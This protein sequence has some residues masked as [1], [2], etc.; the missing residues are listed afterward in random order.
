MQIYSDKVFKNPIKKIFAT[1]RE[2]IIYALKEIWSL[3]SKY[4]VLGYITYE[5]D[6]LY[7]EVFDSYETFE[8]VCVSSPCGIIK[9]PLIKKKQYIKNVEKIKKYIAD[10]FTY[11]VNYTYPWD[12]K[13]NLSDFDLY[14][15][16]LNYQ[17]TPYNAYLEGKNY[18]ILSFSPELFFKIEGNKIITKPMKGTIS[19][20]KNQV[21]DNFNREFLKN[22]EKNR[23]EN[24]MIVD[25]LRNDLS[26]IA[27]TGTV[28]V[29]KLFDVEEH[30]TLFQMTSEVS[31]AL[32]DNIDL[33][34]I[35][36]AIFPCGSI[37]GA[38]KRS[39]MKLINKIEK[40]KRGVYCGAIG[41]LSKDVCEFS[42]PIRILQKYKNN[43]FSYHSGGAIVWDS[44]AKD[45]WQ[46]AKLKA[47]FLDDNFYLIETAV[48]NWH[49]HTMR[50]KKS[51]KEL[52]FKYNSELD[53]LKLAPNLIT[54]VC[55]FRDGT[56]RVENREIL[57]KKTNKVK[58][59]GRVN[60][61][62]P[63]LY[64][65]TSIREKYELGE[66]F[67]YILLNEF[68]EV[69]EGTYTNIAI[70][71]N[72]KLYT[73][74]AEC[75]LLNGVLRQKMISEHKMFEKVLYKNDLIEADKIFCFNS[76]R[77]MVEVELCL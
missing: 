14:N 66:Y 48:D 57:P 44:N 73:P 26:K 77:K 11:E 37:T 16:L 18:K 39:T 13:T 67:D 17:K 7:F 10:G 51:A 47:K 19:R 12:V 33:S 62:N 65:K 68:D 9:K 69:C 42:V 4:H 22:D 35:F 15:F 60:S 74:K 20:G 25:L 21:E 71:K 76:V 38:P 6:E 23:A 31:A 1:N 64:N 45:E 27:K 32:G 49:L 43:N 29:D 24:I 5:F 55:L 72:G 63:F 30:K 2:Q 53:T 3:R 70:L 58:F 40:A 50:L 56:Y 59:F 8:P 28:C 36:E 46:E 34:D 52:G 61:K 75:G 41:Y 54:R